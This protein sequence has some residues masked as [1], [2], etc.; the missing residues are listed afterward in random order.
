MLYKMFLQ[1]GESA[2]QIRFKGFTEPWEIRKLGEVFTEYSIK[3]RADL[4]TLM[5]MQGAGTVLRDEADRNLIY[6]KANLSNYKMV[7]NGDFIVHLR[8]FEGGL[9]MATHT[10]IISPAY[11]TLHGEN[12]D[13]RFYYIYFRSSQFIDCDLKPHVYGIRDGRSIDIN[14]MKSI[15]IPFPNLA[16]QQKIGKYFANLDRLIMLHDKK[17]QKLKSIKTALLNKA[18][19]K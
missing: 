2:P 9:E 12:I 4:P 19:A 11:R 10:G 18:F 8:S 14:G 7:N 15:E 3:N 17:I 6:D 13:P 16:E 1:N 5:I